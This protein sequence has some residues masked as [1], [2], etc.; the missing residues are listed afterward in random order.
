MITI[1]PYRIHLDALA[2]RLIYRWRPYVIIAILLL[3]GAFGWRPIQAWIRSV[4]AQPAHLSIVAPDD[5]QVLVNGEP[6]NGT[7][8]SGS[9]VIEGLRGD[10]RVVATLNL[11]AG[12]PMTVTLT[13]GV[14]AGPLEPI[15]VPSG[16]I[17]RLYRRPQDVVRIDVHDYSNRLH[18]IVV[19]GN[20][21]VGDPGVAAY[22]GVYDADERRRLIVWK[23]DEDVVIALAQDDDSQINTIKIPQPYG[24]NITAAIAD[25]LRSQVIVAVKDREKGPLHLLVAR[26]DGRILPIGAINGGTITSVWWSP[27]GMT[28]VLTSIQR[29]PPATANAAAPTATPKANERP[30]I[31]LIA[32]MMGDAP[33]LAQLDEAPW[34]PDMP[35]TIPLWVSNDAVWWSVSHDDRSTIRSFSW[36]DRRVVDQMTMD[37]RVHALSLDDH[38][39]VR[40][41]RSVQGVGEIARIFDDYTVI[42]AQGIRSLEPTMVGWW[43]NEPSP[44][45]L[46][47]DRQRVWLTT[48][49]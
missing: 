14:T 25:R 48:I 13:D 38:G 46:L 47:I 17:V 3:I 32:I 33:S 8:P 1:G 15:A 24:K 22:Q 44:S 10:R 4:N 28:L 18:G 16:E 23:D 26:P 40:V 11:D 31:T 30:M 39:R 27:D 36:N 29:P 35:V 6:W 37:G 12:R 49:R 43:R 34:N 19:T 21:G 42:E 9:V 2:A 45:I 20:Y 41:L 5:M 7:A